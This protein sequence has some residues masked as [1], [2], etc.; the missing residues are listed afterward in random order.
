[1]CS[2]RMFGGL[3]RT[4]PG[5]TPAAAAAALARAPKPTDQSVL[6]LVI[7][8]NALLIQSSIPLCLFAPRGSGLQD[9]IRHN[10]RTDFLQPLE[11][12][13]ELE[14]QDEAIDGRGWRPKAMPRR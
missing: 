8:T 10:Q 1:M 9:S 2:S 6:V 7:G 14:A 4:S 13:Q 3:I 5:T 12:V 11:S